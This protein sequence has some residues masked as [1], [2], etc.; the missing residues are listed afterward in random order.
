MFLFQLLQVHE[1][2]F[3]KIV[4]YYK[5][6]S[7]DCATNISVDKGLLNQVRVGTSFTTFNGGTGIKFSNDHIPA[8]RGNSWNGFDDDYGGEEPGG[9]LELPTR[10]IEALASS[11][12]LPVWNSGTEPMHWIAFEASTWLTLTA[13]SSG[14]LASNIYPQASLTASGGLLNSEGDEGILSFDIGEAQAGETASI[15]VLAQGHEKIITVVMGQSHAVNTEH[16]RDL[17]EGEN[18]ATEIKTWINHSDTLATIL[19]GLGDHYRIMPNWKCGENKACWEHWTL[20]E[21]GIFWQ[22]HDALAEWEN[23][24]QNRKNKNKPLDPAELW[25]DQ[26][27]WAEFWSEKWVNWE[28][29]EDLFRDELICNCMESWSNPKE[30]NDWKQFWSKQKNWKDCNCWKKWSQWEDWTVF[31]SEQK[32]WE[33]C[34]NWVEWQACWQSFLIEAHSEEITQIVQEWLTGQ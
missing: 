10:V 32:Y 15:V 30:L 33:D 22:G 4:L 20:E 18:A 28:D 31:W 25:T 1:D 23:Y 7:I 13:N 24:L 34:N 27:V 3:F 8:L 26:S 16:L 6:F 19:E 29:W 17:E 2:H 11:Q 5:K 12:A 9:I 14:T 21:W